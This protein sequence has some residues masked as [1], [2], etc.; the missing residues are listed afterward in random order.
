MTCGM[1]SLVAQHGRNEEIGENEKND[2]KQVM[3]DGINEDI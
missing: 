1:L 2:K 3:N